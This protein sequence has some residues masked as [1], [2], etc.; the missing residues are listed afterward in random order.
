[1]RTHRR[2]SISPRL[3]PLSSECYTMVSVRIHHRE[4]IPQ[5]LGPLPSECYSMASTYECRHTL[6]RR[7]SSTEKIS[8]AYKMSILSSVR[9]HRRESIPQ[10]LVPLPIK[11]YYTPY[12]T[13]CGYSPC[14]S[15]IWKDILS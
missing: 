15:N 1:M 13:E 2:T 12:T 14:E 9:T 10:R 8:T 5:R 11:C 4:S 7:V 3:G 6:H